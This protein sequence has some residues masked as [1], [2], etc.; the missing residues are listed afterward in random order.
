MRYGVKLNQESHG[1]LFEFRNMT[2]MALGRVD[3]EG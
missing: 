2:V 3:Y 1:L